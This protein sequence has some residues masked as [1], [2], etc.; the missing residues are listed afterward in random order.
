MQTVLNTQLGALNILL[1]IK[2]YLLCFVVEFLSWIL[3]S[4][5]NG[6]QIEIAPCIK[7]DLTV[8]CVTSAQSLWIQTALALA[9]NVKMKTEQ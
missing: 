5:E 9:F 1:K 2:L 3:Q 7:S 6:S 8:L 4:V